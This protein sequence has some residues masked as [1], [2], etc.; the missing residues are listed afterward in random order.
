MSSTVND[1]CHSHQEYIS[2]L[3][4]RQMVFG[5]SSYVHENRRNVLSNSI[6]MHIS[7]IEYNDIV[8]ISKN[9]RNVGIAC[10][11]RSRLKVLL[12]NNCQN[13][14]NYVDISLLV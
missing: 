5:I 3:S 13:S 6:I 11:T 14:R 8:V 2:P 4:F 9:T 10:R 12:E 7:L 1:K